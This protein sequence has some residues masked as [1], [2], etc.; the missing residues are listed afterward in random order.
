MSSTLDL[1][2]S[3]LSLPLPIPSWLVKNTT[4]RNRTRP[5]QESQWKPEQSAYN[6]LAFILEI[7]LDVIIH[8][9]WILIPAPW[10]PSWA[11]WPVLAEFQ[12]KESWW[13]Q[14]GELTME[15]TTFML[16]FL[17]TEL[18]RETKESS[19]IL[20]IFENNLKFQKS[21]H[22]SSRPVQ[23]ERLCQIWWW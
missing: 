3:G 1:K 12:G 23:L 8:R 13:G 2:T 19:F 6:S 7:L 14:R 11:S 18:K 20:F 16:M 17:E 5:H 15:I 21:R 10:I 9:G 22:T 4:C